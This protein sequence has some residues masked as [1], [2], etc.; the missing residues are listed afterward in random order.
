MGEYTSITV[1]ADGLP[2]VSYYDATN[3]DLKVAHCNNAACSSASLATLDSAG[4]VG[5]YTSITVGADGLPVIGYYD[6]TNR[7][8]KAAHCSNTFCT[9]FVRRR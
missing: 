4:I 3:W 2:I 6:Y 5:E 8:L 9:P 1:G 7:D